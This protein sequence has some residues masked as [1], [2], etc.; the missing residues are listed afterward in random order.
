MNDQPT[1]DQLWAKANRM[2]RVMERR[3]P[4][5]LY[6]YDGNKG[7]V[8]IATDEYTIVSGTSAMDACQKFIDMMTSDLKRQ[9]EVQKCEVQAAQERLTEM[10]KSL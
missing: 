6:G 10:M 2:W 9:I 8:E 5:C 7:G 1:F 4:L 3:G